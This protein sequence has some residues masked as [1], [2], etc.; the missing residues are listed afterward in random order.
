[1]FSRFIHIIVYTRAG[2]MAQ[3]VECLP[4][5]CQ[6]FIPFHD[7]IIFYCLVV[8]HFVYSYIS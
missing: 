6:Y 1:M 4:N 5:I 2:D 7:Q 3:V 8:P